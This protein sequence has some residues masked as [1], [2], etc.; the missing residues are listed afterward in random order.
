MSCRTG[1][2]AGVTGSVAAITGAPSEMVQMSFHAL[3]REGKRLG[4]AAP[5]PDEAAAWLR[6]QRDLLRSTPGVPDSRRL[7]HKVK[8]SQA[9]ELAEQGQVPD[10]ATWHAWQGLAVDV[11]T[12]QQIQRRKAVI[13]D[14]D[15]TLSD[16]APMRDVPGPPP[17]QDPPNWD[18]W[19]SQTTELE[20]REWVRDATHQLGPDEVAVMLTARDEK[21]EEMTRAWLGR[22][23][24]RV[25][26]LHMRPRGDSRPDWEYKEE[27]LDRLERVYDIQ[28]AAEDN[29]AVVAMM[30]E[31]GYPTVRVP[32]YESN[33]SPNAAAAG[34]R[35]A[36]RAAEG[37]DA[38]V[39]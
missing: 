22:S 2:N 32:G 4:V 12:R 29:P 39:D 34:T 31:R 33:H 6:R 28:W 27:A 17:G 1:S 23:G 37:E 20:A 26:D 38:G 21:Y 24:A 8:L 5:S 13:F 25:D 30:E 18:A 9:R 35:G 14:I 7:L 15:G 16:N 3:R 19:M 11:E 10:G 36:G